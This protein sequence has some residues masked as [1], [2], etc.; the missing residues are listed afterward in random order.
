M[1]RG[2]AAAALLCAADLVAQ[3]KPDS[4]SKQLDVITVLGT[5]ASERSLKVPLAVSVV[6]RATLT[7][8]KGYG[9]D[10]VLNLV[11][12]VLAQSRS[13]NQ[14]VRIVIR[15]FGA[16]GAGDRSNAGTSRGIRVLLDG[17]PETEP[18]GRTAFDNIDLAVADRIDVIRSNASSL[19]GNAAGGVVNVTSVPSFRDQMLSAG[20]SGGSYGLQRS[21]VRGGTRLGGGNAF[22]S[23]VTTSFDGWRQGSDSRR[24]MVNLGYSGRFDNRT[25]LSV[26]A[27]YANNLFGIPGPL[28]QAEFDADPSRANATY[29]SRRER[30]YN[31]TGRLGVRVAHAIDASNGVTAMAYANPK[32]LQRSERGT[33][34]DFTR[35]HVGGSLAYANTHAIGDRPS[36]FQVGV[37]QAYQDGAILFYSLTADGER[38]TTV[39]D[40]KREGASNFGV[41]VHEDVEFGRVSL[42]M[43]ARYD[44]IRYIA[45][46]FIAPRLNAQ[47]SFSRITP[48]LGASVR[49]TP[50][51]SVYANFGGGVE[52]PAGNETDPASTFGT[53]TITGINPLLAPI[54]SMSFEAGAK[55]VV[56][57]SMGALRELTWDLAFYQT[58]V[59]NEIVPYRGGRFYFTAGKARRRGAE[60]GLTGTFQ[61]GLTLQTALALSDNRY[62]EYRVDSVHYNTALA[63]RFADFSDN[64]VVGVPGTMGTLSATWRPAALKGLAFNLTTQ[65]LGSYFADDANAIEVPAWTVSNAT[66][67]FDQLA[68]AQ[69][70]LG[71]R[72]FL[73]INNF[74]NSTYVASAFLNPDI[75]N[76]VPVYLEAGL[77]R[78]VVLSFTLER[79]R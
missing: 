33:F 32:Y 22:A 73:A 12:G 42:S 4:A 79:M 11:P 26:L 45:R 58:G 25:D 37:D 55:Q 59:T 6:D 30:R 21:T 16:R 65:R 29:L 39:R 43:G 50:T 71:V 8:R 47:R 67:S 1:I 61:G 63:G 23:L 53:D 36:R 56:A 5:R 72:T 70:R 17:I 64:H 54:R 46:S 51:F 41:F 66:V 27:V 44:D 77:P 18:D 13:G 38:G 68:L 3:A 62:T 48:K 28:T 74:T 20:Y 34:R 35:Y 52:A 31:R 9:L 10:E 15:G 76:N 40:N 14:D 60:L 75:V 7:S 24:T 69:G 49:L 78:N 19:W 57:R 2:I